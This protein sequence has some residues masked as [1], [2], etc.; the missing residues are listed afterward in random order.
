MITVPAVRESCAAI[1]VG[2]RELA[3]AT[4]VGPIDKEAQI[5]TKAVGTTVPALEALRQ[6]LQEEKCTSVAIES[7]GAYWIPVKNI[8]EGALELVRVCAR[9]HHPRKGDKTDFR[10]AIGLVHYHRHGLL[11]GSFLPERTVVELRDMTRRRKKVLGDLRSEKNRIQKV[12]ET[13]NVK[14]GSVLSDVFGVSGQEILKALLSR[15]W[16]CQEFCVNADPVVRAPR[17]GRQP[18]RSPF[19]LL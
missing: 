12:L 14:M 9:K 16:V 7:T 1:D 5:K 17:L 13:A 11:T 6:W 8:L 4:A 3:V 15:Q 18:S 19:A 10:D 2:K